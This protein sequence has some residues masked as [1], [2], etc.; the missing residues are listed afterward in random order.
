MLLVLTSV[1]SSTGR[2]DTILDCDHLLVLSNGM[3]VEQGAPPQL[4]AATTPGSPGVFAGMVA[5]AKAAAAG[6]HH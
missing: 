1:C 2:I 4:A 6:N 5:A 3:L